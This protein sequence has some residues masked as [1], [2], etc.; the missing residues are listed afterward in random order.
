MVNFMYDSNISC[1]LKIAIGAEQTGL[2]GLGRYWA[3]PNGSFS[4]EY[5]TNDLINVTRYITCSLPILQDYCFL[6]YQMCD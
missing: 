2:D 4:L 6:H 5:L 3:A 1:L